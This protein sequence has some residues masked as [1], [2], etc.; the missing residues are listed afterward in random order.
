MTPEHGEILLRLARA[1]I[2]AALERPR[3]GVDNAPW[4][5]EPG[6]S[7]VTLMRHG[8]LRGCIGS[9]EPYRP[10]REDVE[11]NARMAA[12]RDPRFPAL[13]SRD[14]A[15][16]EVEVAV[17]SALTPVDLN[18]E[19]D[20]LAQLRP[21]IDGIVFQYRHHRS[22]FLPQVWEHLPEPREF[23]AH[24]KKKAGLPADFWDPLVSLSRYTVYKWRERDL[25]APRGRT[26]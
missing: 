26:S 18:D 19:D 7:F 5:R 16:I 10:L 12:F 8:E 1:A 3:L 15:S 6:A 14:Y 11:D 2:G 21:G 24:L 4:L 25:A 22:T 9:L 13:T 17:L 20:A 23:L